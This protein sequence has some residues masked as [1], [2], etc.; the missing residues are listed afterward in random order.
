MNPYQQNQ[1]IMKGFFKKPV[2]LVFAIV[3]FVS[4]VTSMLS[5][6]FIAK[7][8]VL[9]TL[10]NQY[11][12]KI[13]DFLDQLSN[14]FHIE[15]ISLSSNKPD[16]SF[17]F[18]IDLM[19]VLIGLAF[20]FF[21]IKSRSTNPVSTLKAPTIM[22]RVYAMILFICSIVSAS[23]GLLTVAASAALVPS[24]AWLLLCVIPGL[25]YF[26]VYGIAI[27]LFS[28]SVKNNQKSIYL[29][30]RGASFFGI[31]S[32]INALLSLASLVAESILFLNTGENSLYIIM[33]TAMGLV[34]VALSVIMGVIAFSYSSYIKKLSRGYV[35]DPEEQ[36][37]DNFEYPEQNDD[38]NDN[39]QKPR[40]CRKCGQQLNPDDYF[41]NHCGTAVNK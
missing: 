32:L 26:L 22:F 8:H 2:I 15:T 6:Y 38:N 27:F 31:M 24:T 3:S 30:N 35:Y 39:A 18:Q 33:F 13:Q 9:D 36:P 1:N 16:F 4:V 14:N 23:L 41:C 28:G 12:D 21:F 25:A 29:S 7:S 37:A 17:S 19:T 20:L 11:A 34:P 40:F 5:G 10:F